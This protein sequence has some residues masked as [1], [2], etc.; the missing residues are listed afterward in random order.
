MAKVLNL[1]ICERE[2]SYMASWRRYMNINP[3]IK[4]YFVMHDPALE[5][6]YIITDDTIVIKGKECHVPGIYLKTV[7]AIKLCLDKP[8][9]DTIQYVIRTNI[10]SFWI[11]DRLLNYLETQESSNF[12]AS[13]HVMVKRDRDW[14]S[15]HG[16]NMVLSRDV[17][18]L[19]TQH[20]EDEFI[21]KQADDIAIG[22]VLNVHSIIPKSYSWYVLLEHIDVQKFDDTIHNGIDSIPGN[23]FTLRNNMSDPVYRKLYEVTSY[24]LLIDKFYRIK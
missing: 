1:I 12:A 5:E 14:D 15:P 11:W 9:F 18:L 19:L 8:E 3:L 16:S 6:E 23:I 2:L 13:G 20:L 17:A 10:S 24:D 4:S 7:N 22:G 21:M